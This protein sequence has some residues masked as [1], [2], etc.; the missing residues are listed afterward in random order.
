MAVFMR[1]RNRRMMGDR[2]Y[3][4]R[5]S[6]GKKSRVLFKSALRK[7]QSGDIIGFYGEL[8]SA[9]IGY[10]ADRLNLEQSALTVDDIKALD[11][12]EPKTRSELVMFLNNVQVARFAPGANSISGMDKAVSEASEL[13]KRLERKL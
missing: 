4:R 10:I 6:A 11:K 7:K 8:Y 13:L 2:A 12:L 3:A 9:I 5:M 1:L